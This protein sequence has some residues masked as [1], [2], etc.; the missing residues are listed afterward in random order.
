LL[1]G[2][3]KQSGEAGEAARA[4]SVATLSSGCAIVGR[5][6]LT[7]AGV[8]TFLVLWFFMDL[9]DQPF[10]SRLA[11]GVAVLLALLLVGLSVAD[12]ATRMVMP[13]AA[14]PQPAEGF[15]AR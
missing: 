11:I 7:I 3:G 8:K 6:N 5:S 9:A 1:G 13:R 12:V 14:A 4:A 2:R 10:R 15:F